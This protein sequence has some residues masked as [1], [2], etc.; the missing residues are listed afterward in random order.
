M[1]KTWEHLVYGMVSF[2]DGVVSLVGSPFKR[3]PSWEM[4]YLVWRARV[5]AEEEKR[6][7]GKQEAALRNDKK[8]KEG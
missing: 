1:N 5:N 8:R 6:R 7:A 3:Y 4:K 2:A